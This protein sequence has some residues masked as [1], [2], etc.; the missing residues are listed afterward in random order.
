MR[1][2]C[3]AL[4]YAIGWLAGDACMYVLLDFWVGWI[5]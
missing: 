4:H 1:G 3:I 5:S 2:S